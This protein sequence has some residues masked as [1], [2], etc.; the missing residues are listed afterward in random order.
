MFNSNF[1]VIAALKFILFTLLSINVFAQHTKKITHSFYPE[2]IINVPL[3]IGAGGGYSFNEHIQ[4]DLIY[5]ITPQPFYS[6][7]GQVAAESAGNSSYRD[8]IEA[9]F[10]NN[11][12]WRVSSTYNLTNRVTGF[13]F[14]VAGSVLEASGDAEI[15]SVLK[16][17]TGRDYSTLIAL[18][19]ASG[20][21]SKV[22]IDSTLQILELQVSYSWNFN[23]NWV[24]DLSGGFLKVV[25]SDVHLKTGLPNYESSASGNSQ[26]RA[27]ENDLESIIE[28]YGLSP[29]AG[30]QVKYLF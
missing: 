10:Q 22:H 29:T 25:N 30:V 8:V 23:Q 5:G 14:T 1:N 26:M 12:L 18:L 3:F 24:V 17:S 19:I 27:S 16:A 6:L 2:V 13:H 9:A 7:I 4:A 15:N 21:S 11:S 20:R 28:E